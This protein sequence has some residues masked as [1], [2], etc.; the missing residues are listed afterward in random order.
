[1]RRLSVVMLMA[2]LVSATVAPASAIHGDYTL[3]RIA[4][5]YHED[6][7]DFDEYVMYSVFSI[8]A[9]DQL[10]PEF[11]GV[12][13]TPQPISGTSI[14]NL[15][16]NNW[17]K[18]RAETQ[19]IIAYYLPGGGGSTICGPYDATSPWGGYVDYGGLT[20]EHYDTPEGNFCVWYVTTGEHGIDPDVAEWTGADYE[21]AFSDTVFSRG[22]GINA[23]QSYLPLRDIMY[24]ADGWPELEE[25][26]GPDLDN[27]WPTDAWDVHIGNFMGAG[28]LGMTVRFLIFDVPYTDRHDEPAYFVMPQPYDPPGWPTAETA[29]HEYHHCIQAMYASGASVGRSAWGE[30]C[31]TW[32]EEQTY[33]GSNNYITNRLPGFFGN[34]GKYLWSMDGVDPYNACIWAFF[35]QCFASNEMGN[36]DAVKN[37]WEYMARGDEWFTGGPT[38][39]TSDVHRDTMAAM[40]F[41]YRQYVEMI[42]PSDYDEDYDQDRRYFQELFTI[43]TGWNWFTGTRDPGNDYYY[44]GS[45]YP[46]VWTHPVSTYPVVDAPANPVYAPDALGAYYIDCTSLPGWSSGVFKFLG[47]LE[48]DTLTR[49]WDGWL[50]KFNGSSWEWERLFCPWDNGIAR[51]DNLSD[52]S[53]IAFVVGNNSIACGDVRDLEF[54]F[55]VIEGTDFTA[56]NI[57]FTSV[58]P[59]S[60]P[61]YVYFTIAADEMLHG[62]PKLDIDFT[63][64]GGDTRTYYILVNQPDTAQ[65]AYYYS[66][67]ITQGETG[68]GTI[69]LEGADAY[70]NRSAY[71][72]DFAAGVVVAGMTASLGNDEVELYLPVGCT[73]KTSTILVIEEELTTEVGEQAEPMALMSEERGGLGLTVMDAHSGMEVELLGRA[74]RI[75]PGWMD[76]NGTAELSMSYADLDVVDESKVSVYRA[77]GEGG[78]V[79]IGGEV[80]PKYD[81][82]TA[83]ISSFG[84]YALGYG[85]GSSMGDGGGDAAVSYSLSQNY[86]NPFSE[87]T[88]IRYSLEEA[89]PVSIKIYNL[90]GQLVDV[91]VDEVQQASTYTAVWD[92]LDS[93]GEEAAS[94]LYIYRM[95]AGNFQSAKKMVLVR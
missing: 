18:L 47:A 19:D 8:F 30:M 72:R 34:P 2:L 28:V 54:T 11:E 85:E 15:A 66:F 27:W 37:V 33:P 84:V 90:S 14:L 61:D 31:S 38:P 56:P 55:S 12:G 68:Q 63:P 74:Y 64:D 41:L 23:P 65:P 29:T 22:W 82:I 9:P 75:E 32:T 1:M 4:N 69:Y 79:E 87:G 25:D 80:N 60:Q 36:G 71:I 89:G 45:L 46:Q 59:D 48:N 39:G 62:V 83:Q 5:A 88:T 43:F 81:R 52:Y 20:P 76:L 7:I 93:E 17:D 77:D 86:P 3:E 16:Y 26:Y 70:G 91:L 6:E 44:E 53:E 95:S 21:Y 42:T 67:N 51:V 78:W 10:P 24:A 50:L 13:L 58:I 73:T 35:I 57:Y 40:G 49:E 92:G 94:G